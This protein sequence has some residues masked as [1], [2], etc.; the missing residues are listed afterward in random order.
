MNSDVCKMK[1]AQKT[2]ICFLA[3]L[4]KLKHEFNFLL[5]KRSPK[6]MEIIFS[7]LKKLKNY[8]EMLL[9]V[10]KAEKTCIKLFAFL[11]FFFYMLKKV[12]K[13]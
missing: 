10:E 4:K 9:Q 5:A 7:S 2:W 8:G 1:K 3:S 11:I 12:R 13:A 6:I